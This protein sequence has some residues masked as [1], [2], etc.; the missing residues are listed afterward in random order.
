MFGLFGGSS[1]E[2][3]A[4]NQNYQVNQSSNEASQ[5]LSNAISS[6][7]MQKVLVE[8]D[9]V[10]TGVSYV[11]SEAIVFAQVMTVQG[12][13]AKGQTVNLRMISDSNLQAGDSNGNQ[14]GNAS[15]KLN[16]VPL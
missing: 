1:Y 2:S 15:G 13:N 5:A 9:V 7:S 4:S 11:P 12:K 16:I 14:T 3:G 10:V 8:G 6:L